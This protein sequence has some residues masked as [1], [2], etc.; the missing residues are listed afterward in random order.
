MPQTCP[1]C[2]DTANHRVGFTK[3]SPNRTGHVSIAGDPRL[4]AKV[5]NTSDRRV[6]NGGSYP[7]HLATWSGDLVQTTVNLPSTIPA[8]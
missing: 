3:A 4:L 7:L 6:V 8:P 2:R 1:G 5:G